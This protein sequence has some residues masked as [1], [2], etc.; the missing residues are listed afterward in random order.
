MS[1]DFI[2]HGY[3]RSSGAYSVQGFGICPALVAV[4]VAANALTAA[5]PDR[6][7]DADQS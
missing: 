7:P 1:A 5:H 4:G 6:Q 2:L 3:R